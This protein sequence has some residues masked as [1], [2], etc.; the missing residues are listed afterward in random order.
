MITLAVPDA[1]QIQRFLLRDAKAEYTYPQPGLTRHGGTPPG[2]LRD[3]NRILLGNGEAVYRRAIAELFA[4]RM[5]RLGWLQVAEPCTPIATGRNV[6]VM[7]RLFGVWWTN[8]ARIVYCIHDE[9]EGPLLLHGFAYGTLPSHAESGEERFL[10][11]WNRETNEVHYDLFAFS[12]V[13]HPLAVLGQPIARYQQ[14]RAAR[15]SL[16]EMQRALAST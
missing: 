6:A 2:Y 4:W 11:E 5:F 1:E 13:R 3:H 10:I 12:R 7:I 15:E 16:Q 9:A 8:G 14:Q